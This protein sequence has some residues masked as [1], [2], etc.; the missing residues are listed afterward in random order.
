MIVVWCRPDQ[1]IERCAA[2][3][4]LPVEQIQR[5]MAAQMPGEEKKRLAD[6]VIDTSTSLEETNGQV[7]E[8]YAQLQALAAAHSKASR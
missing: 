6:Y 1:Q 8:V 2:Q 4:K 7:K 3:F 5:R